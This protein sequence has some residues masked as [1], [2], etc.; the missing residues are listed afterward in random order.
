MAVPSPHWRVL[1]S[2]QVQGRKDLSCMPL[3]RDAWDP[4]SLEPSRARLQYPPPPSACQ[5][6]GH[7]SPWGTCLAGDLL[8][9][10]LAI[11]PPLWTATS[12]CPSLPASLRKG[13]ASWVGLS[14]PLSPV[15][16]LPDVLPLLACGL[17][18]A[19]VLLANRGAML[20]KSL[21]AKSRAAGHSGKAR[22]RRALRNT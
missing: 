10:W 11:P 20:S 3:S 8:G 18:P 15:P 13:T 4:Y 19:S 16:S 2:R 12:T 14:C 22:I 5:G 6:P 1:G 7:S 9:P 17:A 21:G